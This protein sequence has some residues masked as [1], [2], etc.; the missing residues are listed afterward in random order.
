MMDQSLQIAVIGAG[1]MGLDI[2]QSFVA[3]GAHAVV[4]DINEEILKRAQERLA[5]S[6]QKRVDKGRMTEEQQSQ[7]QDG[8]RFTTELACCADADLVVEAAIEKVEVKKELFAA[9]DALVRPETILASNTSSISITEIASSTK[10]PERV[11]GMHFFNP[12]TVMKLVEL[13][14]GMLTSDAVFARARAVAEAAGKTVVEVNECPGFV[15]N[16]LLIPML[17]EAVGLWAEGVASAEDIDSAMKLGCNHPMGPLALADMIG[18]DVCL[19]IMDTLYAETGDPK[20]R[21]HIRLKQM[22]RAG[23]LGRKS[24]RGIYTYQN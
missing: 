2:A 20:F 6:L 13:T 3:A 15:V 10:H 11:L 21:P 19:Y 17:N 14:R 5:S 23:L 8:I 16:R 1:T 9:L 18:L 7:I 4:R 24:G 22:V 12:A